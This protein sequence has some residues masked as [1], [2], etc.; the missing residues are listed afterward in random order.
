M[1]RFEI[2]FFNSQ[3]TRTFKTYRA[4]IAENHRNPTILSRLKEAYN[5]P[6]GNGGGASKR[7]D[8]LNQSGTQ[9]KQTIQHESLSKLLSQFESN[10]STEQ[11]QQ[12]KV[13]FAEGYLA[14]A[15]P[16]NTEKGGRA[17]KY[18]KVLILIN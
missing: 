17:I 16:E 5:Q 8:N 3:Q 12:L 1:N 7:L 18:L 13:A 10:L 6:S 15:H 4:V 2:S 9:T 11:K 14:A